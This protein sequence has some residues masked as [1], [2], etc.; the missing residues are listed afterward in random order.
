[1]RGRAYRL[2]SRVGTGLVIFIAINAHAIAMEG[3]QSPY[4]KGYRDFMTGV[5]PPPGVQVRNDLY[6]Y[7][8]SEHSTIP[9]GQLSASYKTMTNILG[10]TFVTRYQTLGGD[11]GFAV[12]GAYTASRPIS[13]WPPS[14][15]GSRPRAAVASTPS[16]MPRLHP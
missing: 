9:Q 13:R 7:S 11:F 16:T 8:G 12:R 2:L 5:L 1:M 3:I 4:L 15:L 14:S 10:A 6:L